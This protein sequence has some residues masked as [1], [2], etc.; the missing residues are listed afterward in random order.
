[1]NPAQTS[2]FNP[3]D[4]TALLDM[5]PSRVPLAE[6]RKQMAELERLKIVMAN[7]AHLM[8]A[9]SSAAAAASAPASSHHQGFMEVFANAI[10]AAAPLS[11]RSAVSEE[12]ES[13]DTFSNEDGTP[14]NLMDDLLID[15]DVNAFS[16]MNVD[17]GATTTLPAAVPAA[18]LPSAALPS[19]ALP[20]AM[21]S[22]LPA[23]ATV[24]TATA[25]AN[26]TAAAVAAAFVAAASANAAAPG[27]SLP[28]PFGFNPLAAAPMGAWAPGQFNPSVAAAAAVL[29]LAPMID[30]SNMMRKQ[31]RRDSHNAVERRRRDNINDR[32]IELSAL[33][34]DNG[35]E[36]ANKGETLRKAVDYIRYLHQCQARS[37]EQL[38]EATKQMQA[39]NAEIEALRK[40]TGAAPSQQ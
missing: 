31:R 30:Q 21:P 37:F 16:S 5:K 32:I 14:A 34:P 28:G 23:A 10:P 33:V 3:A 15:F 18:A 40:I 1:M 9:V 2:Y 29:G 24:Q 17:L 8:G 4:A 13:L 25:N 11:A 12:D 38:K 20:S 26:A 19:A 27:H 36:K 6:H 22:S 7:S 35:G 39:M